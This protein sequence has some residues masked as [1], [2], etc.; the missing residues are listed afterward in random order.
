MSNRAQAICEDTH[1]NAE[2]H[3]E[4]DS[5]I[6]KKLVG[7]L[8]AIMESALFT[9]PF[10]LSEMFFQTDTELVSLPALGLGSNTALSRTSSLTTFLKMA[11]HPHTKHPSCTPA[12]AFPAHSQ[13]DILHTLLFGSSHGK[14]CK[15]EIYVYFLYGFIP[16]TRAVPSQE[17]ALDYS[18]L[19]K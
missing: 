10:S 14:L 2:K 16:S 17:Q 8:T 11:I 9:R 4:G 7:D 15:G 12:L 13:S 19:N 18:L 1:R 3:S 5:F 6:Q